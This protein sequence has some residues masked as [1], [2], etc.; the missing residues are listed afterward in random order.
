MKRLAFGM[1]VLLVIIAGLPF[2]A[3]MPV[4]ANCPQCH[5]ASA[6]MG[7]CLAIL[8]L[9]SLVVPELFAPVSRRHMGVRRLLLSAALERPPRPA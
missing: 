3:G 9:L 1:L 6:A 8:A 4:M 5:L 2:V 7:M